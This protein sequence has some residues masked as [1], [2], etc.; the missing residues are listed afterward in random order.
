VANRD[1]GFAD[2]FTSRFDS[3]RRTAHA[4]CGNW[5]EAEEIAQ[6]AFVSMY[7][8][9]NKVRIES[10]DAYL[11]TVQVRIE[12]ADAYLHTVLTRAFLDTKRRG[13]RREQVM[14]EPPEVVVEQDTSSVEDRPSLLKALQSVPARQRA[15]LVLRF[16][17]D[18]SVE[19]AADALGCSTGTVKSQTARGLV[20]LRK[21]YGAVTGL[22]QVAR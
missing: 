10:A 2:F 14:A 15:V 11:H 19:E 12:S 7:G 4:L 1:D 13:R 18:L 20:T 22:L 16:I 5:L 3:A 8:R 9:W 17:E 21:A 6:T